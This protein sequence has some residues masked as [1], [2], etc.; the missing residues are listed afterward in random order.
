VRVLELRDEPDLP[1][2]TFGADGLGDGLAEHLDRDRAVLARVVREI[3][4]CR[5]ATADL[6]LDAVTAT[7]PDLCAGHELN[8][9]AAGP[10]GVA[11][12]LRDLGQ[13]CGFALAPAVERFRRRR[14]ALKEGALEQAR[15]LVGCAARGGELEI[16]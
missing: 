2:E 4:G 5:G 11:A 16:A 13:S 7:V 3:D 6:A 9:G 1:L 15:G 12:P 10:R 8:L 14:H